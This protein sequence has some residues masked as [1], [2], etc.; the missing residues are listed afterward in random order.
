MEWDTSWA[1]SPGVRTSMRGNKGRDTRPELAVRRAVHALGLRYRV[2][3]RPEPALRRTADLVFTKQKVAVF[4]DGC[5]W[6][7]CPEHHTVAKTNADYW[8]TKVRD[9]M[10]RDR[11]TTSQLVAA[12][13]RVLRFWEHEGTDDVARRI[14]KAVLG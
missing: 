7:G 10:A 3:I 14:Q 2:N 13:W 6:H 11:E 1:S 12:G 9:N 4:I 8:A 5:F